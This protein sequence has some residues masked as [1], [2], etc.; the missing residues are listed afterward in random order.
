MTTFLLATEDP[1]NGCSLTSALLG[2]PP[3]RPVPYGA[4]V[5]WGAGGLGGGEAAA[6][7]DAAGG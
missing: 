2:G 1:A 4:G 3:R 5:G 6:S 7:A